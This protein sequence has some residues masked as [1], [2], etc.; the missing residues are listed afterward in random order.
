MSAVAVTPRM[1]DSR[2]ARSRHVVSI[3]IMLACAGFSWAQPQSEKKPSTDSSCK[4]YSLADLGNDPE[5]CKWIVETIP[6]V[7]QPESWQRT[8]GGGKLPSIKNEKANTLS[9]YAPAKV[10]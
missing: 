4:I 2:M 6:Q 9:Y 1:E 7:I 3:L 10:L 8:D 5:L